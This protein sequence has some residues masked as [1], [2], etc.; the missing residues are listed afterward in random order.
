M[1]RRHYFGNGREI[2]KRG[3]TVE[4]KPTGNIE[5]DVRTLESA[6]RTLKRK[7]VQ[8][9]VI[10][11]LRRKEYYESKGQIRRRMKLDAIRREKKRRSNIE[12]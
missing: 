9:G 8:E 1:A 12:D 5:S 2:R 10:R 6:I 11:D 4:I 3:L 7:L